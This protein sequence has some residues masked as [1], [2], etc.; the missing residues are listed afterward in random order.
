MMNRARFGSV[1]CPRNKKMDGVDVVVFGLEK[2]KT[3]N[4]QAKVSLRISAK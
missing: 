4:D 2:S 3:T 1:L